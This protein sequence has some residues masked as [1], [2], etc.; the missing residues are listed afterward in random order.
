MVMV[1]DKSRKRHP[2]KNHAP[3]KVTQRKAPRKMKHGTKNIVARIVYKSKFSNM[4][5]YFITS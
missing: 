1:R 3:L 2:I 5:P 4:L